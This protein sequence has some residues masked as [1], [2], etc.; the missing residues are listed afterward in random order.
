MREKFVGS[1][2]TVCRKWKEESA[3]AHA[4]LSMAIVLMMAV[5][6]AVRG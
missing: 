1:M 2:Y 3:T 6:R 5:P 4:R